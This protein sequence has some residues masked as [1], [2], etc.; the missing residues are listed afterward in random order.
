MATVLASTKLYCL[1]A[2]CICKQSREMKVDWS[3]A[4]CHFL[5]LNPLSVSGMI[6]HWPCG[7]HRAHSDHFKAHWR[8]YCFVQPTRRDLA[9]SWLFR[10]LE[11]RSINLLTY[12]L[13][14]NLCLC[15]QY[16]NHYTTTT[17]IYL[18]YKSWAKSQNRNTNHACTD[19]DDKRKI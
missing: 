19:K 4:A 18:L 5:S 13:L 10:P 14:T 1:V 12:L 11:Q 15:F 7:Y 9:L 6:C 3:P 8:Q 2:A 17:H 16:P